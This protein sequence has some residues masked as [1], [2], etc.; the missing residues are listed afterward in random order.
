MLVNRLLKTFFCSKSESSIISLGTKLCSHTGPAC[1]PVKVFPLFFV[2]RKLYGFIPG[3]LEPHD[4]AHKERE[5]SIPRAVL[6]MSSNESSGLT[7]L[8]FKLNTLPNWNTDKSSNFEW[9]EA[10][11]NDRGV[12]NIRSDGYYTTIMTSRRLFRHNPVSR[13]TSQPIKKSEFLQCMKFE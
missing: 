3:T 5:I 6:K 8:L 1:V 2:W 10:M 4:F 13:G 11:C 9:A 12:L 7:F